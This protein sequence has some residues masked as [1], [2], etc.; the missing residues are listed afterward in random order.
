[1]ALDIKKRFTEWKKTRQRRHAMRVF[2]TLYKD[3]E[4]P[5]HGILNEATFMM[6]RQMFMKM[7]DAEGFAHCQLCPIRSPLRRIAEA[8][9]LCE[10]HYKK[11]MESHDALKQPTKIKETE[12]NGPRDQAGIERSQTQGN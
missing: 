10:T 5:M 1:M 12:S 3:P 4:S 7:L 6:G 9:M 2:M 8:G 11:A